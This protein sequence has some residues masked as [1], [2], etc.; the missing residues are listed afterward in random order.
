[1]WVQEVGKPLRKFNYY[2]R[3][4]K[5]FVIKSGEKSIRKENRKSVLFSYCIMYRSELILHNVLSFRHN[6]FGL[7]SSF[8]WLPGRPAV[9]V[10]SE[11]KYLFFA[12]I[13]FH[14]HRSCFFFLSNRSQCLVTSIISS[15]LLF[16]VILSFFFFFFYSHSLISLDFQLVVCVRVFE[17]FERNIFSLL[18]LDWMVRSRT[19][20]ER[21]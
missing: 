2:S 12:Q 16:C 4:N 14:R 21:V 13:R 18:E 3:D 10:Q 17:W 15:A 6:I 7:I 11:I 5:Y 1:M 8:S 9:L 19:F 20:C